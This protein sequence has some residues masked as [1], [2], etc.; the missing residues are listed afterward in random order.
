MIISTILS[1]KTQ[2]RGKK[3]EN[4]IEIIAKKPDDTFLT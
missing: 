2:K 4:H 3:F 1:K